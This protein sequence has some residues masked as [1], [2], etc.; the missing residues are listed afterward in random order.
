MD[1]KIK[2]GIGIGASLL[3][4]VLVGSTLW[5]RM[6]KKQNSVQ[7]AVVSQQTQQA[8]QTQQ[9]KKTKEPIQKGPSGEIPK[10]Y[11]DEYVQWHSV[12]KEI[13][14]I[15]LLR[16]KKDNTSKYKIWE[17]GIIK[18]GEFFG[19]RVLLAVVDTNSIEGVGFYRF[20]QKKSDGLLY[21][22]KDYSNDDFFN[23]YVIGTNK[24]DGEW[25]FANKKLFPGLGANT[26][27]LKISS[28]E[29]PGNII[30]PSGQRLKKEEDYP[31]VFS[32][33]D[34]VDDV[35]F[36]TDLLKFAFTDPVYGDFYMTDKSKLSDKD[37]NNVFAKNGFYVKAP[38][39]TFKVYSAFIDLGGDIPKI[40][41]NDG[42]QNSSRYS[43][44][45]RSGCG[46]ENYADDVS[47][48]V[49]DK[50]LVQI[51]TAENGDMI[52]GYKDSNNQALKDFYAYYQESVK[53]G[54]F[55]TFYDDTPKNLTYDQF[56]QTHPLFFWKDS[57]GRIIKFT[58]LRYVFSLGCGK[59]V[60]YLY[61]QQ[62][63]NV[64]VRINPTAGMSVSEPE[65]NGGWKVVADP[66]SNILNLADNKTY[67]YLFWEGKGDSIYHMPER[68]YVVKRENLDSFFDEKLAQLGLIQKEINDFKDFWL[69][70]M[71]AE[72]KPYYFVTFVDRKTID[73]LAPL[74]VTPRPDTIIRVLM[75]YKSLDGPI[76][77]QGFNITTP[78][79]KGFTVVEWGGVLK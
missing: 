43:Y 71:S 12:P 39:G 28:L 70:K 49:F 32:P 11:S 3:L 46:S 30:S 51:G 35:F 26:Y 56:L 24:R 5:L 16:E 19:S 74:E 8:N 42:T 15:K 23:S 17:T 72:N 57:F 10:S 21:L 61:P 31:R 13:N 33:D 4:T 29:Y 7:P 60:I 14:D 18:K 52:Y 2:I 75:D 64:L 67:P 58:N 76:S 1:K 22:V 40:N 63:E 65:Y 47:D 78:E 68:G 66:Q 27:D 38:D 41:W 69:P 62:K 25:G 73:K 36:R 20:I 45:S 55:G 59:P 48:V 50:D 54:L 6:E 79:R 53:E 37:K 77:V 34:N 44:K 9:K